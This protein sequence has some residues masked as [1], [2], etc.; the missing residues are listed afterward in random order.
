MDEF[1]NLQILTNYIDPSRLNCCSVGISFAPYH[2]QVLS[3]QI[4]F[5]LIS[6]LKNLTAALWHS[7][8]IG[9]LDFPRALNS[10][11]N[12]FVPKIASLR[13]AWDVETIALNL[14]VSVLFPIFSGS[15]SV[16]VWDSKTKCWSARWMELLLEGQSAQLSKLSYH[17]TTSLQFKKPTHD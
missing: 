6:D 9:D 17:L 11:L 10:T 13:V 12:A 7:R 4:E 2:K 3:N 1:G 15:V 14:H 8:V 16:I 5:E